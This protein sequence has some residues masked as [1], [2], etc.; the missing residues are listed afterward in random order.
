MS[1]RVRPLSQA[2]EVSQLIGDF[3]SHLHRRSA[4]D[5]L[6]LMNE[7]GLTMA[8]MV[9]LHVLGHAGAHSVSAVAACLRLSPAA[10]SHLIDR[11][12]GGGLVA[13]SEDPDDRRHKRIAITAAGR[14]LIDRVQ[15]ERTREFTRVISRLSTDLQHRFARVL[16]HVVEELKMLPDADALRRVEKRK[17]EVPA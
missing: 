17:R 16:S 6:V 13:R 15:E 9:A 7:A 2:L 12:V 10:T 5:T 3:M 1:P 14:A 8:Q 11:L 4:G